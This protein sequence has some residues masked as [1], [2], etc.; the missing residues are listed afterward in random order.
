MKQTIFTV[1]SFT[2]R[3]FTGNP[4]GVCLL[5]DT[6]DDTL[7]LQIARELNLSETAFL[8]DHGGHFKLRWFTPSV[9]VDLCGHATL[10][11]A[12]IIWEQGARRPVEPLVFNT[13][14]GQLTARQSGNWIELDFPAYSVTPADNAAAVG[15]ALG[16]AP[17]AVWRSSSNKLLAELDSAHAVRTVQPDFSAVAALGGNG[18]IV[19][20]PSDDSRYDFVSRFFAPAIGINEDPV[21]GAAHCVLT[22]FWQARL[23]K[24]EMMAFQASARGGELKLRLE[25]DRVK[26]L[27]QAVTVMRAEMNL[28]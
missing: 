25:G 16:L 18:I 21:T 3:L 22:P 7:K 28:P 23:G 17:R 2:N 14:S 5:A 19:T 27:G 24:S 6:I 11:S 26:L 9:E 12:H 13:R 10:A 8:L 4:A 15:K 20:A 1:D